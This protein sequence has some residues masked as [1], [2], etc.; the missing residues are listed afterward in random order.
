METFAEGLAKVGKCQAAAC[1]DFIDKILGGNN[2][3]PCFME[4]AMIKKVL[5][6]NKSE[7]KDEI[8]AME[9]AGKIKLT[10]K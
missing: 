2:L 6:E 4:V 5:A 10:L 1:Y 9:K 8:K 7:I 3:I